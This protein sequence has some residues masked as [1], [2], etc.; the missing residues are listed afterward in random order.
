MGERRPPRDE[1]R[2][3]GNLTRT[4]EVEERRAA[5]AD[6]AGIMKGRLERGEVTGVIVVAPVLL[7]HDD[8]LGGT[9]PIRRPTVVGPPET[10]R[11]VRLS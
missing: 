9:G 4:E 11:E 1:G 8:R 3:V 10:E 2:E 5:D 6:I 7:R